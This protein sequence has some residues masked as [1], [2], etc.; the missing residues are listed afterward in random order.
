MDEF[1][2]RLARAMGELRIGKPLDPATQIGPVASER[3]LAGNL[4]YVRLVAEEGCDVIGG[5]RFIC[6]A[7]GYAESAIEAS[8][9]QRVERAPL[10]LT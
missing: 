6:G 3:Q 8:S 2:A 4:D 7:D 10:C 1:A 5:Q 9:Y